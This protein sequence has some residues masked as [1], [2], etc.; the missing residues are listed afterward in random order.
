MPD[1]VRNNGVLHGRV[2]NF[3]KLIHYLS[4]T[5]SF[6]QYKVEEWIATLI[7][8]K[9]VLILFQTRRFMQIFKRPSRPTGQYHRLGHPHQ[10]VK[11]RPSR[12]GQHRG[13][14]GW[15]KVK[16]AFVN[17]SLVVNAFWK[18]EVSKYAKKTI[19]LLIYKHSWNDY[20]ITRPRSRGGNNIN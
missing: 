17:R 11:C 16:C 13:K 12:W 10:P 6:L 2:S 5:T 4:W 9:I 8:I 7:R 20:V 3:N 1:A 19:Y 18:H 15:K 14:E